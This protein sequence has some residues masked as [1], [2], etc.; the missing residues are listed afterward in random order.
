M[1][2]IDKQLITFWG[3]LQNPSMDSHLVVESLH[4]GISF[5]DKIE[6]RK[7]STDIS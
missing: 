5:S 7:L 6:I 2:K 4:A 1:G 3:K